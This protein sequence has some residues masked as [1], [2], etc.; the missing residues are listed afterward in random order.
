MTRLKINGVEEELPVATIAEL[1][2]ARGIDRRRGFS[3]SRSTAMSCAA[4]NGPGRRCRPA[5][6]SRSFVRFRAAELRV[7]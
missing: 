7:G 3:P 2:A 6:M 4:L 5:T 1:L